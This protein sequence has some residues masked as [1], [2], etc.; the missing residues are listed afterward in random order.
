M[1]KFLLSHDRI[2]F[3]HLLLY[4]WLPS[5]FKKWAYR[6]FRGYR[7]GRHV[8]LSFGSIID[9]DN[10]DLGDH[11]EIGLF[12]VISGKTV[13][14]GRHSSIGMMCYFSCPQIE[15]GEDAKI[16]EQVFVGGPSLP[17]SRFTLG[18]RT[19]ILQRTSINPTK[20]VIIGDDSGIGGHCLIFYA[21]LVAQRLAR[22]PG[23]LRAGHFGEKR[24]VAVEGIRDAGHLHWRWDGHRVRLWSWAQSHLLRLLLVPLRG[25]SSR[26]RTSRGRSLQA[27]A[28]S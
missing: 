2:P 6:T 16:R 19:V 18:S 3:R 23:K 24:L 5:S 12:S 27:N 25:S 21:Q 14:I 26:L 11:V 10:V 15:I 28:S 1:G 9:A 4:G 20:P 8:K 13:R 17:E 7:I 22:L